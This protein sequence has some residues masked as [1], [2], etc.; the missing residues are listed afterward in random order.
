[1][2]NKFGAFSSLIEAENN[3]ELWK[4]FSSESVEVIVVVVVVIAIW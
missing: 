4:L 2:A 3:D 1:M